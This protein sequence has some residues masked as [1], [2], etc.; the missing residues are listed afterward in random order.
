MH[1]AIFLDR[2]GVLNYPVF[3]SVTNEYEAPHKAEDFKLFPNV[4]ESLKELHDLG[5]KLFVVSNQPDFAKGKTTL[6]NLKSVHTQ[7]HSILTENNIFLSEYYYCYHHPKGTVPE[8]TVVCECRKPK[9]LFLRQAKEKY[10]LDLRSSWMIGD[11]DVDIY[12]GQTSGTKTILITLK[13]SKKQAGQS[14]PDFKAESL[15]EAVKII[16]GN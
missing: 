1:K 15:A 16:K 4:I 5:Y 13:Q 11:R 8:Y 9:D 6:E 7:M 2:D 12:C 14:N 10:G 3:N